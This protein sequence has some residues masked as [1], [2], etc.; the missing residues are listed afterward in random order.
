MRFEPIVKSLLDTDLYKFNMDQVIFHKHTDLCG[1]YFFKCRNKDVVFT[2]EMVDEINAQID[3]LCSLRFK[4]KELDYL[5]SIRFIKNDYVE[6]L[7]LWHPLRD[8]VTAELSDE[9]ELHI[10]VDGPLFSAMQFEIYLLEIVN[11]VYF[12]MKYDYEALRRSANE[13]LEQKIRD[14]NEGKYN[15]KFAEFGCRRRLSREWEDEVV[16]RLS[17][18]LINKNMVGTSNV[19]LAMKYDLTPIG[20]YAHEFVQMYQG[21]DRIPLAY[22]NHYAMR[23]WY[24]EYDGDNGTALTDTVTTDL[25]L[26]DFN[27]SMVNNYTGVRHD[28]GDPYEWGEKMIRHYES[29]G[30]DPK[31]KLLLFSDS[32]DFDR[33]EQLYRYFKDKTKV[34]F[35]IGTFVTNDT[36]ETALN[37]VIKLQYVNGRPVAKLSDT[38]GKA[39]CSDTEYLEYLKRSVEFRIKRE[40]QK[41]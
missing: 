37:I 22:T 20:T 41:Q 23:D 40:G 13:K 35:G 28:S 3:H 6:F 11:E 33:A 15:F 12:R 5:R 30:V 8:Y 10:K 24:D 1:Q 2:K 19:Y 16:R 25:F 9:G 36:C 17:T 31:T 39:M 18:E 26:L 32:L 34:S 29:Y 38:P 21:I 4:N 27:R 7:R 14:F